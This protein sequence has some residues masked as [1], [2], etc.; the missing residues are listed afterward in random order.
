LYGLPALPLD[1]AVGLVLGWQRSFSGS[2]APPATTHA[3][4]NLLA[5]L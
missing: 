1:F 3:A 2:W 4:A 5:F